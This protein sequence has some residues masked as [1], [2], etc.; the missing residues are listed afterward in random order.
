MVRWKV[1][2]CPGASEGQFPSTENEKRY[3]SMSPQLKEALSK[4]PPPRQPNRMR[5]EPLER[6]VRIHE[7]IDAGQF[8][9]AVQLA[10][11]FEVSHKTIRRDIEYMSMHFRLPIEYNALRHGYFYSTKVKGFP[12]GPPAL[13]EA[14]MFGLLVAHK[15]I[16]Q[17]R[18]TPYHQPLQVAFQKLAERLNSQERYS[19]EDFNEALSFRPFAPEDHDLK[20]FEQVTAAL[21][22]RRDLRFGYRKPGVKCS[23]WRHARPYH[24]LCSENRWYLLAYDVDRGEIRTFALGRMTQPLMAGDRF[25]KPRNFDPEQY[26]RGS[27]AVMKGVGDYEVLIEFDSWGTDQLRGRLWHPTQE[28]IELPDGA[29]S[30]LRMQLTALEEVERWV[31]SWGTHATVIKPDILAKRVGS[32][33]RELANRYGY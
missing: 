9:N 21:Q 23:E 26:L 11:Q 27:F 29:G 1:P 12:P 32:V 25:V 18:G 13:T 24:L 16:A 6:M 22:A 17:Y 2:V 10:R 19:L 5:R 15:A 4:G 28:L 31:A 33:S 3:Q 8:P 20:L 7:L 30:R 14:E